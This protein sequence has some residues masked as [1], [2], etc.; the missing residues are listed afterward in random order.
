MLASDDVHAQ[1][2]NGGVKGDAGLQYGLHMV[3]A[4]ATNRNNYWQRQK[5]RMAQS[6]RSSCS[7]PSGML[8]LSSR[9]A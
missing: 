4:G 2:F 7:F 1:A 8:A 5:A 6:R 9:S 3:A